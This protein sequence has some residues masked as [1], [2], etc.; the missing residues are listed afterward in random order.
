MELRKWQK[1]ALEAVDR[2]LRIEQ[3]PHVYVSAPT[4]SGKTFFL[5]HASEQAIGDGINIIIVG[6]NQIVEQHQD[7]FVEFGYT[8]DP[9]DPDI[10]VSPTG[11]K[12]RITT[13]QTLYS[14]IKHNPSYVLNRLMFDECHLGAAHEDSVSIPAILN[15]YRPMEIINVSATIQ[16]AEEKLLG[17]KEGHTYTYSLTD[18]YHDGIINDVMM[19]EVETGL[20]LKIEEFQNT[21]GQNFQEI[22]TREA[23][24][25]EELAKICKR[26][27]IGVNLVESRNAIVKARHMEMIALYFK[28]FSHTNKQAIFFCPQIAD[29]EF[30]AREFNK[31]AQ[32]YGI[33]KFG[34]AAHGKTSHAL[35][36]IA[37]FKNKTLDAIFVVGMLQEGFDL[38]DLELAFDC[39]TL[40]RFTTQSISRLIQRIGRI[41]RVC[42]N[43]PISQYFYSRDIQNFVHMHEELSDDDRSSVFTAAVR[44]QA[45]GISDTDTNIE[46]NENQCEQVTLNDEALSKICEK[47]GIVSTQVTLRKNSLFF[48]R[49][50]RKSKITNAV[51]FLRVFGDPK[52]YTETLTIQK[53]MDFLHSDSFDGTAKSCPVE[54]RPLLKQMRALNEKYDENMEWIG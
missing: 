24:S 18:A 47:L 33:K 32:R 54:F 22:E 20:R 38:P 6:M 4:G 19:L 40:S 7:K 28:L 9:I 44:T 21:T 45:D 11:R 23:D 27:G 46:I 2:I 37:D 15:F 31:Y 16:A 41:A 36:R 42:D 8:V 1:E 29:A 26:D 12:V 43:K 30:A 53:F 5:H 51:P 14:E 10:Y 39:R 25:L 50:A 13:W 3:K 17:Q 35:N 48:V 52:Q 49:E 34:G